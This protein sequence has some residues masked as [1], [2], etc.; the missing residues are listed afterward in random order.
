[1]TMTPALMIQILLGLAAAASGAA[2]VI[3]QVGLN[4]PAIALGV[5]TTLIAWL[6]KRP[7]AKDVP[8]KEHAAKVEEAYVRGAR[9]S[10]RPAAMPAESA[11][12][13]E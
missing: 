7:F 6:A 12:G 5:C 8:L 3:E 4:W 1:M 9:E 11:D 10:A 2:V 13:Q